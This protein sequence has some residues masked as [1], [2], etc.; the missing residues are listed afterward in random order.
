MSHFPKLQEALLYAA[1]L[2]KGQERDG[3]APLPY[4]TH[5]CEVLS[6]LR[7]V[8]GCQDEDMLCAAA[9]H[10]VIE[11]CD[12]D[13]SELEERFG[14]RVAALVK[15]LTRV[16]PT[17]EQKKGLSKDEVWQMRAEWL[18]EEI[19]TMAPDAQQVK[20]ADRLS[21]LREAH[22]TKGMKKLARYEWQSHEILKIVP[23]E[24]NP[25]LWESIAAELAG[26]S[27]D[28]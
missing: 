10:D 3:D 21:N 8:G 27:A 1:N 6:N 26:H 17:E 12:A 20:L 15:E 11:E 14:T 23:R 16:E 18:L 28:H 9:L 24:V 7:Y 2:H 19:R 4:I 25:G 5:P 13:L 22:R